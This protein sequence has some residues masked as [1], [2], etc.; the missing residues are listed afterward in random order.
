MIS[1]PKRRWFAYSLR[2][3]FVVVTAFGVWLGSLIV[4]GIIE[5]TAMA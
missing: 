5:R 2:T 1:A 3:L 4:S